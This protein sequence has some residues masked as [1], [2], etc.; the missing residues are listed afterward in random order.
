MVCNNGEYGFVYNLLLGANEDQLAELAD[1]DAE[2]PNASKEERNQARREIF[3]DIKVK[4]LRSTW[5]TA[6][7]D[8]DGEKFTGDYTFAKDSANSL[9]F[10]G[11]ATLLNPDADK[12]AEDYA[13]EYR[14][15]TVTEYGLDE[16]ISMME[17]YLYGSDKSGEANANTSVYKKVEASAGSIDE[18]KAK[19]N[20]LL[21]AF[22]TDDGS[23][24]TYLGYS[25]TPIPDGNNQETYKQEFADAGRE[26]LGIGGHAGMG[27]NSYIMVATDFGYHIMFYSQVFNSDYNYE[28]LEEYLNFVDEKTADTWENEL[29]ARFENWEDYEDTYLYS[30]FE[31]IYATEVNNELTKKEKEILDKYVYSEDS[32]VV[33]YTERYQDL[34]DN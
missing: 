8:F 26:L 28:T 2:N 32:G 24:N 10:K 17:T 16:F 4:D 23:L 25:V 19:I 11:T 22:S 21:F 15:D 27:G 29:K 33:K 6:G 3:K 7:Y 5:I 12:N 20:E 30:L 14:V 18:D 13:P 9:E 1:W 31:G 34:L